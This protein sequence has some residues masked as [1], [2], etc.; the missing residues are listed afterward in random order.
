MLRGRGNVIRLQI[1]V[2]DVLATFLSFGVAYW[3]RVSMASYRPDLGLPPIRPF[4]QYLWVPVAA[5]VLW[6]VSLAYLGAYRLQ[7]RRPWAAMLKGVLPAAV[8]VGLG[9]TVINSALKPV[10]FSRLMVTFFVGLNIVFIVASRVAAGIFAGALGETGLVRRVLVVGPCQEAAELVE[11]FRKTRD[12]YV[13]IVGV[14]LVG[15]RHGSLPRTRLLGGVRELRQILDRN[16]VDDAFFTDVLEHRREVERAIRLCEEVGVQV[17]IE[18]DLFDLMWSEPRLERVGGTPFVTFAL[19]AG[20]PLALFVK[21]LMDVLISGPL[22]VFL[23]PLIAAVAIG[24]RLTSPGGAIFKQKRCG[25]S[26]REFILYK[27]RS[28][29]AGSELEGRPRPRGHRGPPPKLPGDRR[30]TSF[31]RILRR[32]SLDELPQLWNVLKGDMS[33]VGPRP[34]PPDEVALYERWQRRRLSMRPGLTCLW[35]VGGR[36]ELSF[37]EWMRLDLEYIDNWSLLLDVKIILQTLP[38]VVS[39][40]GSY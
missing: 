33:I 5:S 28:M 34:V 23:A 26:G 18:A 10:T 16:V 19:P 7:P 17:H 37:E 12:P 22:L 8:V 32:F 27:F 11:R 25:L 36:S 2:G 15:G 14:V 4:V 30:V 21:R 40:R 6:M 29:R 20:R 31:G 38:A 39:G 3:L 1:V 35:Q 9:L 24:V 13:E